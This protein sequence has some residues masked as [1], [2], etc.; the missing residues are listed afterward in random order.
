MNIAV[1]GD[2]H[3]RIKQA[4]QL[5][6]SWQQETGQRLDLLLQVGDLGVF[7]D[8][9]R[10]DRSTRRHQE[11]DPAVLGFL[12]H[13]TTYDREIACLLDEVAC[14]LLFVPG[15]HEDHS[16]LKR[17]EQ[18]ATG[19]CFSIDIYKRLFCLKTGIPYTFSLGEEAV[20][21]L[22]IGRIGRPA[23]SPR[24]KPHYLQADEQERLSQLPTL[25]IDLLL[26]HDAGRD[27]IY[28]GSG[29]EAIEPICARTRPLYHFFGH[30]GGPYQH[31]LDQQS[32]THR[33]KM[34]DLAGATLLSS[35][36]ITEGAMG[37]LRWRDRWRH[38]FDI[39]PLEDLSL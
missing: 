20:T 1:F 4:L 37:I 36:A 31:W 39:G 14:P 3:G 24:M 38:S 17:C 28:P 15:N 27:F 2:L 23:T 18:K 22:G 9:I 21:I 10:L 12:H 19:P 30:Y 32:Q 8:R 25:S 35:V 13:F 33:Y 5:S 6:A 11:H 26:T 16:W 29:I 7:P 34:A